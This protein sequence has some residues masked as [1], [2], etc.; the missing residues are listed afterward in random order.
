MAVG[1]N[2]RW[3]AASAQFQ[4][5]TVVTVIGA[6]GAGN[7]SMLLVNAGGVVPNVVE[8]ERFSS[9]ADHGGTLPRLNFFHEENRNE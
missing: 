3:S 9:G 4:N 1:G 7:G 8:I 2:G 5:D 6:P